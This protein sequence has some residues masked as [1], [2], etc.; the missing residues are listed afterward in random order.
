M[1]LN[2][3]LIK[4]SVYV[5]CCSTRELHDISYDDSVIF[6]YIKYMCITFESIEFLKS[7]GFIYGLVSGQLTLFSL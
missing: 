5:M 3:V 6:G 7:Y 4:V 1:G 2:P